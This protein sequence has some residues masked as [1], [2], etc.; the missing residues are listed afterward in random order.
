MSKRAI[1]MLV[2]A[3][4]LAAAGVWTGSAAAQVYVAP[5]LPTAITDTP[6]VLSTLTITG[7]PSTLTDL[8][9]VLRLDHTALNHLD[10]ALVRGSRYL[11]LSSDNGS[12]SDNLGNIRFRDGA[13]RSVAILPTTGNVVGDFRPEGGPL[14]LSGATFNLTGLTRT[15]S[16]AELI[17]GDTADGDWT[18][19]VDDDT[20]GQTGTLLYWSLE[21]NGATDG[22]GP[23]NLESPPAFTGDFTGTPNVLTFG[24]PV[25]GTTRWTGSAG[26]QPGLT[27]GAG[28]DPLTPYLVAPT[29]FDFPGTEVAY[30]YVHTGGPIAFRAVSSSGL[31]AALVVTDSTGLPAGALAV[32]AETFTDTESLAFQ[33]LAAGTYYVVVENQSNTG[34]GSDFTLDAG[35][36][37]ANDA[38]E[39]A[40][41]LPI[42]TP[43]AFTSV[44]STTPTFNSNYCSLTAASP[45]VWFTLVPAQSGVVTIAACDADFEV[46]LSAFDACDGAPTRC[47]ST[48]CA[49]TGRA[50]LQVCVTAGVPVLIRVAGLLD[51]TGSGTLTA[52]LD[53]NSGTYA[54]PT[55]TAE[56]EACR[57]ELDDTDV[58]NG[59]CQ[60]NSTTPQY[61]SIAPGETFIGT[62]SNSIDFSVTDIDEYVFT[63]AAETTVTIEGQTEFDAGITLLSD[64]L[65]CGAAAPIGST[66]RTVGP[67]RPGFLISETLPAGTYAIS[68]APSEVDNLCTGDSRGNGYWVRLT[69]GTACP[70]DFN[71]VGGLTVQDIFDYLSA[72]FS[73][74]PRADFNGAGGIT[75]QDI[76]DYLSAYFAG[77][78]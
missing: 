77:C 64:A 52:T 27:D 41:V 21:F 50:E 63:L 74:D 40:A 31:A 66:V 59:G 56:P 29:G 10:I 42:G 57:G 62:L 47:A 19:L 22:T 60:T 28:E 53:T 61:T 73:N 48:G 58:V 68:I 9:L 17:A 5:G 76:F 36:P 18:L 44:F 12:S 4:G 54:A 15:A 49:A 24:T 51:V 2:A 26:A 71:G 67:C 16:F 45:D 30:R 6:T 70:A 7:G 23:A 34:I 37:P 75:V 43:T 69:A 11:H 3:A 55:G 39:N 20:T 13:F 46:S 38:C 78:P 1:K 72:Y 14:G 33:N 25:S 35:I 8:S 65:D 32:A